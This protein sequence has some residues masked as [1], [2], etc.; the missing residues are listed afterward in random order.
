MNEYQSNLNRIVMLQKK[1]I[2]KKS[3]SH[4][5]VLFKEQEIIKSPVKFS[6]IY[7]YQIG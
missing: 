2:R 1:I 5:G 7:L 4:T 6:G 3:N